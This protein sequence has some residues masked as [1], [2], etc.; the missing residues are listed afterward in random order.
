M[1]L[2]R[3]YFTKEQWKEYKNWLK[4][5]KEPQK[6]KT[7]KSKSKTQQK[8]IKK[9]KEKKED[10]YEDMIKDER[11]KNKRIEV[12]EAKG[13]ICLCCGEREGL[14]VHHTYYKFGKKPW[15]YPTEDLVVLCRKCHN[16]VHS[17]KNND[18]YPKFIK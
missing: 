7:P 10:T 9:K 6:A 3:E 11:W 12:L 5:N 16:K 14:E 8:Q 2:G 15:E 1:K 18:L 17:D 4:N 13:Y